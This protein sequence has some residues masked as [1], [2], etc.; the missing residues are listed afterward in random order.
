MFFL[1]PPLTTAMLDQPF[2]TKSVEYT[3]D[4]K[5]SLSMVDHEKSEI[6]LNINANPVYGKSEV[7]LVHL[8]CTGVKGK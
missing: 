2:K 8:S 4:L 3:G 6:L 1:D 7:P 5:P